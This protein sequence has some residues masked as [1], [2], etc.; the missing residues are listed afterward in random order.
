MSALA[1]KYDL[2]EEKVTILIRD[3]IIPATVYN[4][5][6][7]SD[8]FSTLKLPATIAV[9][10]TARHFKVSNDTVWKALRKFR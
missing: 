8:Y 1:K 10:K 5:A 4:Y 6:E 7:M 3:G 9:E 2:A